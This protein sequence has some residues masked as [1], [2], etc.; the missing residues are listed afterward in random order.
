MTA[1]KS[2]AWLAVGGIGGAIG[3][4]FV[5]DGGR[6]GTAGSVSPIAAVADFAFG[7]NAPRAGGTIAV[8]D[9]LDAW[10]EAQSE[11]DPAALAEALGRAAGARWS[12]ERDV[13]IEALL[14]RLCEIAPEYAAGVAVSLG[15]DAT[16][17][18]DAWLAW[19]E[20]DT[21]AALTGLG[22]IA[23]PELRRFV[24][25]ALTDVQG[26][27][28]NGMARV[29]AALP[30]R[31]RDALMLD[32]VAMRARHD[33]FGAFSDVQRLVPPLLAGR[34]LA[35]LAAAWAAQ[36]PHAALAQADV[37]PT[38]LARLFRMSLFTE[39]A[40]TDADGYAAYLESAG[41]TLPAE[42]TSGLQ[43][44]LLSSPE[45]VD[46]LAADLPGTSGQMARAG[47]MSALALRDPEAVKARVEGLPPGQDRDRIIQ[48]VAN[49]LAQQDPVAALEWVRG[50]SPPSPTAT[51]TVALA[52]ARA[53]I[54]MAFEIIDDPEAFGIE[55]ALSLTVITTLGSNDPSRAPALAERLLRR[56]DDASQSALSNLVRTWIQSDPGN[57]VDWVLGHGTE[58]DS[59]VLA[60]AARAL[61]ARDPV[62][63][64]SFADRVPPQQRGSWVTSVASQYGRADPAR[65]M[66]W[67]A[68]YQGQD[69]YEIAAREV[70]GGAAQTDPRAAVQAFSQASATVQ[71][72]TAQ[73]VGTAWARQDP[74]AAARWAM[75]LANPGARESAATGVATAWYNADRAAA[76]S[77]ILSQPA[78]AERDQLL[79]NAAMRNMISGD[80]DVGLFDAFTSPVVRAQ[81]ATM[82]IITTSRTDAARA[83]ALLEREITDPAERARLAGVIEENSRGR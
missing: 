15:L 75:S 83:R 71:L 5:L 53:D 68:N 36:D 1:W 57:A 65:A 79:A 13:E 56:G 60:N 81:A 76:Q 58:V 44:L 55:S 29:G 39:W 70:I 82:A 31:E 2:F 3:T 24:A 26:D 14:A 49:T 64:A 51:R 22:R 20:V 74:A 17:A 61:A 50:L 45:R 12:P 11:S 27:D 28:A 10:R 62:N 9:Q 8:A 48:S 78:G 47:A 7:R 40:R 80:F 21:A 42:W 54:D 38:D 4:Y 16:F 23:N 37:L 30:P 66:A 34:A 67:I 46:R 59:E 25:L 41:A 77:W 63:A 69:Y 19:A 43:Y 73:A 35:D 52:L 6:G 72:G 32:W 33:P 18:A